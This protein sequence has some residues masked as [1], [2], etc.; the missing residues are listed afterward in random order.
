MRGEVY[1]VYFVGEVVTVCV[2]RGM[3]VRPEVWALD[4]GQG[5]LLGVR[6]SGPGG[7]GGSGWKSG[8]CTDGRVRDALDGGAGW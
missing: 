5:M 6:A 2:T 7:Q 3:S 4:G 1:G 8:E